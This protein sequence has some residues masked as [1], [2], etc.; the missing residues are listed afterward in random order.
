MTGGPVASGA[1]HP[2][3]GGWR[4]AC[5]AP[6]GDTIASFPGYFGGHTSPGATYLI[7]IFGEFAMGVLACVL[8]IFAD[9]GWLAVKIAFS[10]M[11]VAALVWAILFW[12][13]VHFSIRKH[14]L[15]LAVSAIGYAVVTV[16]VAGNGFFSYSFFTGFTCSFFTG[17]T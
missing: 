5:R 13:A 3:G 16:G 8:I 17:F 12:L 4:S 7:G 6:A 2:V 11:V 10:L 1:S 15:P 14:N 9:P